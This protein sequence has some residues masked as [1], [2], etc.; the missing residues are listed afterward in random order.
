[1]DA[2]KEVLSFT[3]DL[4][5]YAVIPTLL[6]LLLITATMWLG[7][8][9][10]RDPQGY[11]EYL[12]RTL[13]IGGGCFAQYALSPEDTIRLTESGYD[14]TAV[15]NAIAASK[16]CK[17]TFS[18]NIDPGILLAIFEGESGSGSNMGS[19]DG[20]NAA[21]SNPNLNPELEEEAARWLLDRWRSYGLRER[22]PIA[23]SYIYPGYTGYKGHCSAGEIGGGGFIPTT[24][25]SVCYNGLSKSDD[26]DIKACNFWSPK[27][28]MFAIAYWLDAIGYKASL[29]D[30]EKVRELVGWNHLLSY[31]ESL[32]ERAKAINAEIGG[33]SLATNV[34]FV[35]DVSSTSQTVEGSF[36]ASLVVEYLRLWGLLPDFAQG[37]LEAPLKPEDI[38]FI[39]QDFDPINHPGIDFACRPNADVLA[40]GDGTVVRVIHSNVDFGNHIWISHPNGVY[41]VYAHLSE[42]L[43][44]PGQP[45][46]IGQVIGNCGSTGHSTGPHVHFGVYKDPPPNGY[47]AD[48]L[49]PHDFLGTC[50]VYGATA[51]LRKEDSFLHLSLQSPALSYILSCC[52]SCKL[53]KVQN[54][55]IV[56]KRKPN[57]AH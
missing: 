4:L 47:R 9:H 29:S 54:I 35:G 41:T 27:G 1:M 7:I 22:D 31:R 13:G 17:S 38:R 39:S 44:T 28:T 36:I 12:S 18:G 34:S 26:Y 46:R 57:K 33:K 53:P 23:A 48:A 2:R 21:K 30:S 52:V 40:V 51:M 6:F 37:W 14:S 16:W 10:D 56:H 50:S 15:A 3:K 8:F 43:V 45:V 42:T 25:F 55:W 24:A 5:L 32:V 19:C 11:A 20:I 49:N